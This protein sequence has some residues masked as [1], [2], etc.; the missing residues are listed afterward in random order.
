MSIGMT[1][2]RTGLLVS[3]LLILMLGTGDYSIWQ[4]AKE[5]FGRRAG[6]Q[7]E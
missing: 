2:I 7:D 1:G 5:I 4:P 3:D 6:G